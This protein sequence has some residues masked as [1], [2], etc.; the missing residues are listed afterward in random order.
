MKTSV[1]RK[2]SIFFTLFISLGALAGSLSMFIDP[3]G[4]TTGMDGLLPGLN[5][6]PFAD[7]LFRDLVFAG[8]ALLIVNGIIQFISFYLLMKKHPLAPKSVMLCGIILM[9]WISI[10]FFI[11]PLNLLSVL[12]FIFGLI[13]AVVGLMYV[14]RKEI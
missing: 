12:Y 14:K 1:L 5:K 6:L 13:E 8:I 10:Q 7:I 4:K 2:T 11:Y 9:L 3:S